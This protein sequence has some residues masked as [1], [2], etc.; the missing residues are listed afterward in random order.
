MLSAIGQGALAVE[1]RCDDRQTR[2][3][4]A[5]LDHPPTRVCTDAERRFLER[6]GGGCQVPMGAHASLTSDG[7]EFQALLAS[8]YRPISLRHHVHGP[9]RELPRMALD[10]AESILSRGGGEILRELEE[11]GPA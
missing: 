10:A 1:C 2:E 7:G 8:P 11:R 9:E 4:L 3:L 5:A 6:M